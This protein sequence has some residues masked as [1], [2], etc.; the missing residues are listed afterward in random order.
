MLKVFRKYPNLMILAFGN[1]AAMLGYGMILPIMP[2]YMRDYLKAS[3][4][5]VGLFTSAFAL[6]RAL[7]Q[8]PLGRLCDIHGRKKLIVPSLYVYAIISYIYSLVKTPVGLIIARCGQGVASA[9]LWPASDAMIADQVNPDERGRALGVIYM[10]YEVG[11]II[12]P[13]FGGLIAAYMGITWVFYTCALL[14]LMGAVTSNL[15]LKETLSEKRKSMHSSSFKDRIK[16]LKHIDPMI[17]GVGLTAMILAGGWGVIEPFISLYILDEFNVDLASVGYAFL[18]FTLAMGVSMLVGGFLADKIG[19]KRTIIF[20]LIMVLLFGGILLIS[21]IYIQFVLS[22]ML[23]VF[24]AGL[25]NPAFSALIA[26]LTV[27]SERGITYGFLGFCNDFGFFIGP[28]LGGIIIDN[29]IKSGVSLPHGVKL[30]LLGVLAPIS[31]SII[32]LTKIL[33]EPE[34]KPNSISLENQ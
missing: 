7:L 29:L 30:C 15:L 31:L 10:A 17:L 25:T 33:R 11:S 5:E 16:W 20:G 4:V 3:M 9:G 18:A 2:I 27:E 12:G 22:L 6:A 1:A 13:A 21:T 8:V 28:I 14:S 26:D 32:F 23:L 34:V 19:R 24:F